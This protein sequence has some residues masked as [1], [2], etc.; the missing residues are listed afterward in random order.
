MQR[1]ARRRCRSQCLGVPLNTSAYFQVPL[2]VLPLTMADIAVLAAPQAEFEK[3]RLERLELMHKQSARRLMHVGLSS[4]F[5][6]WCEFWVAKTYA[7]EQ[8][9]ATECH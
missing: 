4:A 5:S 3:Q 6:G 9:M 2:F 8:L 7:I 1:G